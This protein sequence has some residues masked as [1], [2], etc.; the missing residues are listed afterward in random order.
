MHTVTFMWTTLVF[1]AQGEAFHHLQSAFNVIRYRLG[2]LKCVL[3][4]E[5][6]KLMLLKKKI[7]LPP[8]TTFQGAEIVCDW[9]EISGICNW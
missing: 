8:V 6:T 7:D 4:A 3:K 1:A 5:Q 9:V 2:D